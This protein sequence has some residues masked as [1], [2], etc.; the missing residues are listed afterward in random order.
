MLSHHQS[1]EDNRLE[2]IA[3]LME[4]GWS[5]Q[6]AIEEWDQIQADCEDGLVN[7]QRRCLEDDE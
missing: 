6:E 1:E 2:F 5:K 3:R 4:A 7:F